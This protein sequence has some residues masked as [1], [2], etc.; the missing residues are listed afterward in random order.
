[1]NAILKIEIRDKEY[2]ECQVI[3][4]SHDQ[5]EIELYET[6]NNQKVGFIG[7]TLKFSY[8]SCFLLDPYFFIIQCASVFYSKRNSWMLPNSE[9][10]QRNRVTSQT[11]R[12]I[13]TLTKGVNL[14]FISEAFYAFNKTSFEKNS[15][16]AM[17]CPKISQPLRVVGLADSTFSIIRNPI[18]VACF[19]EISKILAEKKWEILCSDLRKYPAGFARFISNRLLSILE[20]PQVR[21]LQFK[22]LGSQVRLL[23][24]QIRDRAVFRAF[25]SG[26]DLWRIYMGIIRDAPK[27]IKLLNHNIRI[28][29]FEYKFKHRG[30]RPSSRIGWIFLSRARGRQVKSGFNPDKS[31]LLLRKFLRETRTGEFRKLSTC[32]QWE[33]AFD[34]FWSYLSEGDGIHESFHADLADL[35]TLPI[36]GSLSKQL[37]NSIHNHRILSLL[38]EGRLETLSDAGNKNGDVLPGPNPGFPPEV[39]KLRVKSFNHLLGLGISFKHCIATRAGNGNY[40]FFDGSSVCAE[41]SANDFRVVECRDRQNERTEKSRD[42][43]LF[44]T[45]ELIRWQNSPG[46]GFRNPAEEVDINKIIS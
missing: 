4:I 18:L 43:V 30:P 10:N 8:N 17:F 35:R 19:T 25:S 42:F 46:I 34:R 29:N 36:T 16:A 6:T 12:A 9:V 33:G 28:T 5:I 23:K 1:M 39:E 45:N 21:E 40:F 27:S 3:K 32:A 26:E 44:L 20:Y 41:V 24:K 15:T 38:R 31:P 14:K 11:I 7:G 13:R 22:N 37:R 2:L